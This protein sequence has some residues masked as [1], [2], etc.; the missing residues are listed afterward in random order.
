MQ[1]LFDMTD[2]EIK[3]VKPLKLSEPKPEEHKEAPK[4][5]K[6]SRFGEELPEEDMIPS[7]TKFTI[8]EDDEELKSLVS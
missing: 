2:E 7:W 4:I 8:D 5:I 3:K 6:G 1:K